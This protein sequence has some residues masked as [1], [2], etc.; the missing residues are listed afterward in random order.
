MSAL[1]DRLEKARTLK[2]ANVAVNRN[3]KDSSTVYYDEYE[4]FK[5]RVHK[6]I[7][8]Q[9]NFGATVKDPNDN[10][11]M[12]Q[13]IKSIVDSLGADIARPVKNRLIGEI[14]DETMGLGPLEAFLHDDE[15]TEIM[16]NG[17]SMVY[18]E[19]GGKLELSSVRFRDNA[20]VLNIIDKIIS[21]LGRRC[22]ESN[23]MVDARLPD[24]SRVNAIIPPVSLVGPSIT[25]RKFSKTPLQIGDLINF[26]SI[27]YARQARDRRTRVPLRINPSRRGVGCRLTLRGK[28]AYH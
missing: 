1:Q 9:I 5:T 28:T 2:S 11:E 3:N 10:A 6:E 15:I 19:R 25:I 4:T 7:I 14:F 12:L 18:V 26:N 13:L 24:G 20:H 22:D 8:D 21:P 27:S 17:P 16:V 23:P